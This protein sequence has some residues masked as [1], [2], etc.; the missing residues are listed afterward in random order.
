MLSGLGKSL[1]GQPAGVPQARGKRKRLW[2]ADAGFSIIAIFIALIFF[3]PIYWAVSNSLRTPAET[4]SPWPAS[5]SPS[6]ISRRRSRIGY[7]RF[8]RLR[9]P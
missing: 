6:S 5:A 3:F 8:R 1:F 7:R 4:L 9:R 2:F